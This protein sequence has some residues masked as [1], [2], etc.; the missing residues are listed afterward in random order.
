VGVREY[1]ELILAPY[2]VF[3]RLTRRSVDIV[4]MLDGRRDLEEILL[5]RY[6]GE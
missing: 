5:R 6:L 3:F 2:R 1:R 4:G